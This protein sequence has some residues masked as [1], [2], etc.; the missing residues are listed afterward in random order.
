MKI[1][2]FFDF[3]SPAAYLA[4]TQRSRLE[5]AG[6][7][8]LRPFLLGGVFKATGNAS[9]V[10]IP[11]KGKWMTEDLHRW[12]KRYG[13]PLRFPQGFPLNTILPM[14]AAAALE[15]NERFPAYVTATYEAIFGRGENVADPNV[16]SPALEAAGL[17]SRAILA[18]AEEQAVKDRLKANTEEAVAR[19]AF[20]APTFFVGDQ[21]HFGND[22]I[23]WVI[24]AAKGSRP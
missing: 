1:E 8:T 9:P 18:M 12:A 19:G 3:G 15:G 17:D 23:D 4:W 20:G 22:R 7:V 5:A 11:A 14:R 24:E 10:T 21:M 13:A 2:F 6:E 16:I